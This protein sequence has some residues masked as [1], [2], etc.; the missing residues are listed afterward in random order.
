MR[1]FII[2]LGA[3]IIFFA[4]IGGIYCK[5]P[6]VFYDILVSEDGK[7]LKDKIKII[8]CDY[9]RS[10]EIKR[11][12]L[13]Y[14]KPLSLKRIVEIIDEDSGEILYSMDLSEIKPWKIKFGNLVSRSEP[15]IALGVFKKTPLHNIKA[16]RC[17]IYNL[18][19]EEKKLVPRIRISKFSRPMIDF[20]PYDI[21]ADGIWELISIE[22]NKDKSQRIAAYRWRDFG[23]EL[24]YEGDPGTFKSFDESKDLKVDGKML[25]IENNKIKQVIK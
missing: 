13:I 5:S 20:R 8:S 23:F 19:K 17:F 12:G 10:G 4:L 2:S 9:Y 24:V 18:N 11:V 21:D 25:T 1:K 6:S 22:E 7:V 3:L 14:R 15:E 16:K